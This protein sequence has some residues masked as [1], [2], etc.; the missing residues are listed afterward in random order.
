MPKIQNYHATGAR[1]IVLKPI[2]RIL[3]L[4][5][6]SVIASHSFAI[7]PLPGILLETHYRTSECENMETI[8]GPEPIISVLSDVARLYALPCTSSSHDDVTYR[9]YLFETGE[10]GGIR[11]LLFSLYTP[12]LGWVGTDILRG[13]KLDAE[14]GKITH[15]TLSR[16]GGVCSTY[17]QWQW[18]DFTLKMLDFRVRKSCG[19]SKS[20]K[21]WVHIYSNNN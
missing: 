7:E 15:K 3:F 20:I 18:N 6:F 17:G 16:W 5:W 12:K 19:T 14:T 13:V 9:V 8:K 11:P 1:D 2:L 21:D 4:A 10:I